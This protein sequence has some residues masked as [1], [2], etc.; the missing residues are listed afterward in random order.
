MFRFSIIFAINFPWYWQ[1]EIVEQSELLALAI[2]SVILMILTNG[3]VV[4]L[5]GEVTCW[6]GNLCMS[7]KISRHNLP[8]S[9]LSLSPRSEK[10]K[11]NR[12]EQWIKED[13]Q[14]EK[15]QDN[16]LKMRCPKRWPCPFDLFP[17]WVGGGKR[18]CHSYDWHVACRGW[19]GGKAR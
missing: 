5:S 13:G 11:K 10:K 14:C 17:G 15:I 1:G 7:L 16:F 4:S 8:S 3:S 2:I 18:R 19:G 9:F 6:S 12:I